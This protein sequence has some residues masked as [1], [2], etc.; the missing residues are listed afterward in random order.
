MGAYATTLRARGGVG[1]FHGSSLDQPYFM[2]QR[3]Y[4]SSQPAADAAKRRQ[5]EEEVRAARAR[6][7]KG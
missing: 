4:F 2:S 6:L 7:L 3:A 5:E 1:Q